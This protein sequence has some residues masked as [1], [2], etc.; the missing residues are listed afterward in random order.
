MALGRVHQLDRDADQAEGDGAVPDGSHGQH[1][2]FG[3]L[4]PV[5]PHRNADR[6]RL[7]V[8]RRA[9]GGRPPRPRPAAPLGGPPHRTPSPDRFG[10]PRHRTGQDSRS[11]GG[12]STPSV[13]A[14]S[15]PHHRRG[16]RRPGR[17]RR[18]AAHGRRDDGRGHLRPC[19]PHRRRPRDGTF[20][21]PHGLRCRNRPG[22]DEAAVRRP[23]RAVRD[24]A[25]NLIR[26][27]EV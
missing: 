16:L 7:P 3:P 13:K 25:G 20:A 18:R 12:W 17:R 1:A 4:I 6:S 24:P 26:V 9:P 11:A 27:H 15:L 2:P 10:G 8:G 23:R 22:A 19:P 14:M 21:R 5:C